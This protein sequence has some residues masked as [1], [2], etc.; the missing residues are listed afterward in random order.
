MSRFIP[1]K[2]LTEG[3]AAN[4]LDNQVSEEQDVTKLAQ[5]GIL[6]A[7]AAE[8]DAINQYTQIADLI[9]QSEKWLKDL[10]EPVVNDII[11]EEKKHLG[12][13]TELL[14]QLP[15]YQKEF[16]EGEKETQTGEDT[17]EEKESVKESLT[18]A[19]LDYFKRDPKTGRLIDPETGTI[20]VEGPIGFFQNNKFTPMFNLDSNGRLQSINKSKHK[21]NNKV[22]EDTTEVEESDESIEIET[23]YADDAVDPKTGI[24]CVAAYEDP[25]ACL[26]QEEPT[27][28][29]NVDQF[30][31]LQELVNNGSL[32]IITRDELLTNNSIK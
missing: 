8:T 5:E 4:P 7:I 11:A 16:E 29:L 2:T 27:V 15:G 17:T 12:Q 13:L 24:E 32:K 18:E 28:Y 14:S 21:L 3:M 6:T 20:A 25:Q 30:E 26:N 22:K 1:K 9:F 19:V 31:K 10:A 23:I